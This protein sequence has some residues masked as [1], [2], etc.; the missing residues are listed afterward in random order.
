VTGSH[1]L[2]DGSGRRYI[3]LHEAHLTR[4]EPALVE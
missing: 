2:R 3:D 1:P 4:L